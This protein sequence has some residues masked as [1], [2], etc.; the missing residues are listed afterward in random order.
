MCENAWKAVFRIGFS[1]PADPTSRERRAPDQGDVT[2][3]DER[4][5]IREEGLF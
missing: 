4:F 2:P 3:M 5:A 1:V